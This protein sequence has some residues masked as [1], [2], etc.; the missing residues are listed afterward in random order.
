M[1]KHLILPLAA[2]AALVACNSNE[3]EAPAPATSES[4]SAASTEAT[5][6]AAATSVNFAKMDLPADLHGRWGMVAADCE[7][8]RADAK[9]L[10]VIG[11]RSL[12]Y[13]ESVGTLAK[14]AEMEPTRIRGEFDF[15]GEGMEWDRDLVLDVQD[16][17]QTLI[18]RE[19]GDDAAPGLLRYSKCA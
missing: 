13:Y 15:M 14:L 18:A 2:V 9:G 11:P 6:V 8:G 17:G 19:Y 16:D 1:R 5:P 3:P 10:L 4:T 12:E 7:Q